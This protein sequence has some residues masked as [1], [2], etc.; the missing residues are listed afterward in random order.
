MIK[1][2]SLIVIIAL[3]S[4]VSLIAQNKQAVIAFYNLENLFDT[5]DDPKTWDE[6]FLPNGDYQWN[7]QRYLKKLDNMA[8][9][10][11]RIAKSQGNITML[12][13]SEIENEL[14]LRDLV[15]HPKLKPLNLDIAHY[16]SPDRRGVDVALLY[17][18]DR[19]RVYDV[20]PYRL[21]TNDTSFRTRDQ[22]LVSGVLDG[23]DTLHVVVNHWPSKL[24]GEKRSMPKR[25]AAA[26]LSKH[27]ADS[28]M[29]DNPMAKVVIMGDLNDNPNAKSIT[30]YLGAKSKIKDTQMYQLYNPMYKLYMDG[31]WSYV[32]RDEPNVIDQIIISYGLINA[33]TKYRYNSVNIFRESYM[34]TQSGSYEGYPFRTFAGGVYQGGYSDH[35]PVYIIIEKVD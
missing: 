2:I 19:F 30:Q 33:K 35:L 12:G 7:T 23:I 1:K 6:Q 20:I 24:G 34:L 3:L 15:A 27:I 4:S 17:C 28:L 32:Y 14:V 18:K 29:Q 26:N 9:V 25:I 5:I 16:D 13:V 8:T 11:S 31:V 10:I 21:V 22:L